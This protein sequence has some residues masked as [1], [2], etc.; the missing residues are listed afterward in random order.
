MLVPQ[1]VPEGLDYILFYFCKSDTQNLGMPSF[2]FAV[3]FLK[4]TQTLLTLKQLDFIQERTTH[5]H[6]RELLPTALVTALLDSFRLPWQLLYPQT[7]A[8]APKPKAGLHSEV[9]VATE[10]ETREAQLYT[11]RRRKAA[12]FG[13]RRYST[14]VGAYEPT[15]KTKTPTHSIAALP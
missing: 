13:G 11:E 14:A 4:T 7:E 2:S 9:R 1:A 3:M 6:Q 5:H 12:A 8:H 10:K 15:L